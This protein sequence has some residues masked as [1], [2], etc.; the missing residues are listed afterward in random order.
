MKM[1]PL[2]RHWSRSRVDRL[3]GLLQWHY[4][5][6]GARVVN[7]GAAADNVYFI[8]DGGCAVTK[9]VFIKRR[10][11]W[12]KGKRSWEVKRVTETV[13]VKLMELEGGSYFGEK[14]ILENAP[15]AATVSAKTS[16]RLAIASTV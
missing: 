11:K 1:I 9:D 7:Q 12:P 6:P 10:N 16:N 2:F 4:Y 5:Q 14:G 3:C 13:N 8:L 15:R